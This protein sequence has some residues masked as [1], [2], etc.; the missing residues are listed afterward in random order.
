MPAEA[1]ETADE[2]KKRFGTPPQSDVLGALAAYNEFDAMPGEARFAFARERFLS[3]KT[4][5]QIANNKRQ[6]LENLSTLGVVP[7]GL[8][9]EPHRMGGAKE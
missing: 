1:R 2:S 3:I 7:R 9:R 5:Q 6:L 8:V 4:L